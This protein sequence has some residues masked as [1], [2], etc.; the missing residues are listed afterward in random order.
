MNFYKVRENLAHML[1]QDPMG[2]KNPPINDPDENKN[3]VNPS[4]LNMT[5]INGIQ[6][7]WEDE[8]VLINPQ[9]DPSFSI[10]Y[11]DRTEGEIAAEVVRILQYLEDKPY[12][13][14]EATKAY[15]EMMDDFS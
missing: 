9:N 15:N 13:K 6:M 10:K 14:D 1:H 8:K 12:E 3:N 11:E 4:S 2:I 5:N 7:K